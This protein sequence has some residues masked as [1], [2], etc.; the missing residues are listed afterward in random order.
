MDSGFRPISSRCP[1][2]LFAS[3]QVPSIR[4]ASND[5]GGSSQGRVADVG[6]RPPGAVLPTYGKRSPQAFD[7]RKALAD[8][9]RRCGENSSNGLIETHYG[10]VVES[11]ENRPRG[12]SQR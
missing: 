7:R 10:A 5:G 12:S 1:R 2:R 8:D 3:R 4:P 11:D 6:G 9:F